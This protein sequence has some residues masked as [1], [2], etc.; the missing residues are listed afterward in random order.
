MSIPAS[1]T[2]RRIRF[3]P[4]RGV[5]GLA[6]LLAVFACQNLH[7]K[8]AP[9]I[10]IELYTAENGPVYVQITDV[11]IGGKTDL[12]ACGTAPKIDKSTYGKLPKVILGPGATLE[13]GADGTLVLTKDAH[14]ACVVPSNFRFEKGAPL[15]PA[16]L[17]SEASLQ[18]RALPGISGSDDSVRAFKP[19]IKLVFVNAPDVELAEYLR[20]D[21]ASTIELWQGYLAKYPASSHAAA[22]RKS[23]SSILVA[24]GEKD[25]QAYRQSSATAALSYSGLKAAKVSA[26]QALAVTPDDASAAKLNQNVQAELEK[27]ASMGGKELETYQQALISHSAGYRF[28]VAA[29]TLASAIVDVDPHFAAGVA[30]Q[31]ET[32]SAMGPID[33]S[34]RTAESMLASKRYDEAS[35][36]VSG[37][38]A[39]AGEIPVISAIIDAASAQHVSR[40]QELGR[41]NDWEG[42]LKEFED[43]AKI[44]PM[45]STAAAIEGARNNFEAATNKAAAAAAIKR[46]QELEAQGQFVQAYETLAG[47]PAAQLAL[48]K[49]DMGRLAAQYVQDA[50][51]T[52]RRIEQAHD[53]IKGIADELEIENAYRYLQRAYSI[54]NDAD[55][56]DRADNLGSKLSEYYLQEAKRYLNKPLAS[57][58]GLGWSYLNKA[59]LYKASNLEQVRD[60]LTR[61]ASAYQMKS[62][63]S[64]RVAFRDQTSRRDSAGFA[65][66]LADAIATRLET[67]GLPVRVIRPGEAPAVEPNFQLVGDVLQ[68]RR[69]LI[70]SSDPKDSKYRAG[71]QDTP[72]EEWNKANREYEAANLNHQ[73]AQAALQGAIARGKKNDIADATARLT[74]AQKAV[75][76]ARTKLDSI[77]K[78]VPAD[79]IKPYTYTEKRTDLSAMVELQFR[80]ND[81]SGN[82]VEGSV[83]VSREQNQKF[84]VLENVKPEDTEGVKMQ[85]TVPDEIQ[86]LTDVE[87]DARDA[88]IKAVKEKVAGLPTKILAQARK[89]ADDGDADSAAEYYILYLNSTTVSATPERE[90]AE[91]FLAEH[92]NIMK[93][94]YSAVLEK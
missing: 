56:K 69:A 30:L 31:T 15:S 80:I 70:S 91:K 6:V 82:P 22:A 12:R 94:S 34:L 43:A 25:L 62:R 27:L 54:G 74:E 18:A 26:D 59:L 79:I 68:H 3:S 53:P 24:H 36:A 41:N 92:Y 2:C 86:F 55:L 10:A 14:S 37:Y 21:W 88:L 93:G 47:L 73:G 83:P 33:S 67:S 57:G 77:P 44:K 75:E 85:G 42:A 23:F 11:L 40:G 50:S 65:D 78:T 35:A 29:Q 38:R 5:I 72:N 17:A 76:N 48:V 84:S 63:L 7:A 13:F 46:S 9:L 81:S 19:G 8:D 90:Q 28:L 60:E 51:E 58:V 52:S 4:L 32:A 71:E 87:N 16:E 64:V 39:F 66:Q 20:A 49:N 1:G 89:R 61:A 45:P